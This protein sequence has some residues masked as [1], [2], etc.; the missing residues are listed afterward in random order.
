M[1]VRD[2]LDRQ[3]DPVQRMLDADYV[4][5]D[6]AVVL[7]RAVRKSAYDAHHAKRMRDLH[8]ATWRNQNYLYLLSR[9]YAASNGLMPT[10]N[11]KDVNTSQTLD[12]DD[13][14]RLRGHAR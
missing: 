3:D 6:L 10:S 2:A 1:M 8:A 12:L 14:A 7:T 9:Q 11:V 13:L 4:R 5:A